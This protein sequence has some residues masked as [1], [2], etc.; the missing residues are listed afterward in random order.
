MYA[1]VVLFS[2]GPRAVAEY[3]DGGRVPVSHV[4]AG[5]GRLAH[6]LST[7][8]PGRRPERRPG[9]DAPGQSCMDIDVLVT[10]ALQSPRERRLATL[11]DRIAV[12]RPTTT[13]CLVGGIDAGLAR[14]PAIRL[15]SQQDPVVLLDHYGRSRFTLNMVRPDFA[16]YSH[17]PAARVFEAAY[18]GSCLVTDH[19]PGLDDYLTPD[20]ECL[21]DVD[22]LD[23]HLDLP[24]EDRRRMTARARERSRQHAEVEASRL[25]EILT[26]GRAVSRLTKSGLAVARRQLDL[27]GRCRDQRMAV[28]TQPGSW[29]PVIHAFEPEI[30]DYVGAVSD[31][32]DGG[33]QVAVVPAVL[34]AELDR[35]DARHGQELHTVIVAPPYDRIASVRM[36]WGRDWVMPG[37]SMDRT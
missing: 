20:L 8:S 37:C 6:A 18:A 23:A 13:M 29:K 12:I 21:V 27:H 31:I 19:F 24:E 7:P 22:R 3:A 10:V 2:G 17:T 30:V 14:H 28:L 15:L 32:T 26:T 25:V 16:G 11:L 4:S 33:Y 9:N 1:G 35:V 34:K 36:I 5:I